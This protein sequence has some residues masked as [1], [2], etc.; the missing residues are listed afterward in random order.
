M[1]VLIIRIHS[2]QIK[3]KVSKTNTH[4]NMAEE[5]LKRASEDTFGKTLVFWI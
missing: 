3:E 4:R 1:A 2:S 5:W